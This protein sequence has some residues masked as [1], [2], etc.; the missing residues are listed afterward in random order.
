[1]QVFKSSIDTEMLADCPVCGGALEMVAAVAVAVAAVD[2][3]VVAA[4]AETRMDLLMKI[5]SSR[6]VGCAASSTNKGHYK[7]I[8]TR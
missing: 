3:V 4:A 5:K 2:A 1:M 6:M 8:T 7:E